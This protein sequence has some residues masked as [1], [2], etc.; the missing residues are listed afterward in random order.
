MKLRV[1][2]TQVLGAFQAPG[3]LRYF[4]S[5]IGNGVAYFPI[6][7]ATTSGYA[8]TTFRGHVV[9]NLFEMIKVTLLPNSV[10]YLSHEFLGREHQ[11]VVDDPLRLL[12]KQTAVRMHHNRLLMLDRLVLTTFAELGRVVEEPCSNSLMGNLVEKER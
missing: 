8:I 12:F 6:P 4:Q 9:Q 11:L 1:Q 2:F 10:T 3:M 7:C 5:L